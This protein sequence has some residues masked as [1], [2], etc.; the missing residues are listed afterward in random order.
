MTRKHRRR[1]RGGHRRRG[2][3]ALHNQK[4]LCRVHLVREGQMGGLENWH[5]D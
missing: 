4:S 1:R 2:P 5:P 3:A